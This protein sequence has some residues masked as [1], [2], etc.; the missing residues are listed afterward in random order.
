MQAMTAKA[1][2]RQRR[3]TTAHDGQRRSTTA[4]EGQRRPTNRQRKATVANNGTR[5]YASTYPET[6]VQ[7]LVHVFPIYSIFEKA[8]TISYGLLFF[9]FYVF[10]YYLIFM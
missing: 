3:P 8:R 5:L 10:C 2:D 9:F 6:R 4:N 7:L 1:K